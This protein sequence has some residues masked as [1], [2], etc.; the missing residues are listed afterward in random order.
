LIS[1]RANDTLFVNNNKKILI[2][3]NK[4]RPDS[5]NDEKIFSNKT[6]E[7]ARLSFLHH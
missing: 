4:A 3:F 2:S 1:F 6:I 5:E 7:K